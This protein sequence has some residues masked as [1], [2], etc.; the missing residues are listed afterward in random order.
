MPPHCRRVLRF[1]SE[2]LFDGCVQSGRCQ[3]VRIIAEREAQAASALEFRA[4]EGGAA[5]KN[6][7]FSAERALNLFVCLYG[8]FPCRGCFCTAFGCP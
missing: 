4:S 2:I 7:T 5:F 1:M 3:R 6:M 8:R